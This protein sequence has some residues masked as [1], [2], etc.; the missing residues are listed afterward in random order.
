MPET[1]TPRQQ[2]IKARHAPAGIVMMDFA[3][4]NRTRGISVGGDV[5]VQALIEKN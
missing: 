2:I 3:G 5:L 1:S 4:E